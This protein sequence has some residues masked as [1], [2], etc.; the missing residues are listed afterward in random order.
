[1]LDECNNAIRLAVL[2]A[3]QIMYSLHTH[4]DMCKCPE[5]KP[6]QDQETL[7]RNFKASLAAALV[8][9][10][11]VDIAK[12]DPELAPTAQYLVDFVRRCEQDGFIVRK[13]ADEQK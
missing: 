10:N 11:L 7:T 4:S 3:A 13:K 12:R 9:S 8:A 2:Q 1:M 6:E 5:P